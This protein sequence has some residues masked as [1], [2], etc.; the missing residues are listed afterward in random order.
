MAHPKASDGIGCKFN[1]EANACGR[2]SEIRSPG[3]REIGE[4]PK[5]H[6]NA[7]IIKPL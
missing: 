1:A 6:R 7:A 5:S 2:R 3:S 4:D